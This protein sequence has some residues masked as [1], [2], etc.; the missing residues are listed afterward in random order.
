MAFVLKG[1]NLN[2]L[3]AEKLG[4]L[5]G[6]TVISAGIFAWIVWRVSGKRKGYAFLS[7]SVIC[8]GSA[9]VSAHYFRVGVEE[10]RQPA[11]ERSRRMVT[12]LMEVVQQATNDDVP[13]IKAIGDSDIDA[14]LQPLNALFR[15]VFGSIKR[16]ENEI[17]ALGQEDVFSSSVL[18]T[19]SKIESEA[20]KRGESQEIIERCSKRIPSI[21]ESARAQYSSVRASDE[22]KR[23]ALRGFDSSISLQRRQLEEMFSLRL[24]REKAESEFLNFMVT[25]FDDYL[26]EKESVSFKASAN[27]KK[28][29][30]LAQS[31]RDVIDD[32]AAFQKRQLDAVEAAKAKIR[33]LAE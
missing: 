10:G 19:K 2:G 30:E 15:D 18:S 23:G 31:I 21:I 29:N 24:R 27:S 25:V 9:F 1:A 28:Y 22:A 6:R 7:F 33:K 32:A 20:R 14:T 8:A 4:E 5:V 17:A 16:M 13:R 12:N 26:L 3:A 11:Q